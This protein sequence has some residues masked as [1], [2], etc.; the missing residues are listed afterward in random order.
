MGLG[1]SLL[2]SLTGLVVVFSILIILALATILIAKIMGL[3]KRPGSAV[4]PA[5]KADVKS[6][7]A[8]A[9]VPADD[10]EEFN[11]VLA[12]LH[13]A[14]SL[15]SGIPVDQMVITSVRTVSDPQAE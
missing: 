12:V 14:L 3:M 2:T 13:G 10:A 7:A 8:P 11:E 1:E 15:A 5:A 6:A 4:P 9:S